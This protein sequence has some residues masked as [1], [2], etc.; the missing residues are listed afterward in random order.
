MRVYLTKDAHI[1]DSPL[2]QR[3][4]TKTLRGDIFTL[5]LRGHID[6]A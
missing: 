4:N 6:F 5:Q 3:V 1:Q 2:I